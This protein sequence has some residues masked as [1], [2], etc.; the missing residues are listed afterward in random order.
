MEFFAF[1]F[2]A[3]PLSIFLGVI[4]VEEKVSGKLLS[5][6]FGQTSVKKER[7]TLNCLILPLMGW[8][9]RNSRNLRNMTKFSRWRK[10][11]RF[12]FRSAFIAAAAAS[13]PAL[14]QKLVENSFWQGIEFTPKLGFARGG[15]AAQLGK[16]LSF[17][18]RVGCFPLVILQCCFNWL[19][20]L[21][22]AITKFNF[23]RN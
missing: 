21:S 23:P 13:T 17:L 22:F 16:F 9:R 15:I 8:W 14:K 20:T 3:F 6:F 11:F 7:S 1:P 4:P 18:K 19:I 5:P 2:F 12:Q 10:N